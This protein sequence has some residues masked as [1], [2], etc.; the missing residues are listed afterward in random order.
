MAAGAFEPA[1]DAAAQA[2]SDS[3]AYVQAHVAVT[4]ALTLANDLDRARVHAGMPY[5]VSMAMS[6]IV[7]EVLARLARALDLSRS[8]Y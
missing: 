8:R 4:R 1:I 6:M 2:I 7:F 5:V 3:L